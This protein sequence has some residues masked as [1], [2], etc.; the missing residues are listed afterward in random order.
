[1]DETS[2]TALCFGSASAVITFLGT[3]MIL[4]DEWNKFWLGAAFSIL[5]LFGSLITLALYRRQSQGQILP[6]IPFLKPISLASLISGAAVLI[7]MLCHQ[8][9]PELCDLLFCLFCSLLVFCLSFQLLVFL[10]SEKRSRESSES[11]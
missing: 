9:D 2:Y 6:D 8:E 1:M 10:T 4:M 11:R 7:W 3:L 5:G